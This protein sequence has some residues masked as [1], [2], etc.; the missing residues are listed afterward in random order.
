MNP[1]PVKM[2][3]DA[4]S[5][6]MAFGATAQSAPDMKEYCVNDVCIDSEKY[7]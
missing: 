7:L 4:E 3:D 6:E 5:M 2:A 1:T